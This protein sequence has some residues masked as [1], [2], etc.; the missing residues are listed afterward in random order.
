M[1]LEIRHCT[2]LQ[3]ENLKSLVIPSLLEVIEGR[4]ISYIYNG[5]VKVLRLEK[6]TLPCVLALLTKGE[7]FRT[8]IDTGEFSSTI[9]L[10]DICKNP[11]EFKEFLT[12][13]Q[14]HATRRRKAGVKRR[15]QC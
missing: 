13:I 9:T 5:E 8:S 4:T 12:A 7:V 6:H 15:Q 1:M 3:I 2:P 10:L 11:L 14:P